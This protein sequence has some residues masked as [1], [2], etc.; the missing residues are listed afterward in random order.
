[1]PQDSGSPFNILDVD[2]VV[3]DKFVV[4]N[5]SADYAAGIMI[6]SANNIITNITTV[7]NRGPGI[8]LLLPEAPTAPDNNTI[9][10]VHTTGNGKC[11]IYITEGNSNTIIN[12]TSDNNGSNG[13]TVVNGNSNQILNS[14]IT[15]NAYEGF[16][17]W[18]ATD[19][20]IRGN[21][22]EGNGEYGIYLDIASSSNTIYNNKFSNTINV[23]DD[24]DSPNTWN[25]TEKTAGTNI[26]GGSWL[27]GNFWSDYPGV[28]TNDDGI[29]DTL[30][31]YTAGG[32]ITNGGDWLPLIGNTG[33]VPVTCPA[34]ISS[35]GVYE[36]QNDCSNTPYNQPWD[37]IRITSSDV[38]FDGMG[39]TIDGKNS[40]GWTTVHGVYAYT[41]SALSNITVKNVTVN[42][43]W[44]GIYYYQVSNGRIENITGRNSYDS[45]FLIYSTSNTVTNCSVTTS[46]GIALWPGS[47]SNT[48]TNNSVRDNSGIA[49]YN[50][51]NNIVTDNAIENNYGGVSVSGSSA[52]NNQLFH[53]TIRN[54]EVGI[55]FDAGSGAPGSN[56]IYDNYFSNTVNINFGKYLEFPKD[57]WHQ[58]Y[59][60][61]L[62]WRQ[63][64]GRPFRNRLFPDVS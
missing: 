41:G 29:G 14:T 52:I 63:L 17:L 2:G 54:N 61:F 8:Y 5:S 28:D 60:R 3:L 38:E 44:Q 53:N 25:L 47:N 11:G 59:R 37:G 27:G 1:M 56:F 48:I 49:I 35:P 6:H 16:N 4:T 20:L 40:P 58:Y 34:V 13:I 21:T 46:T 31:P 64:L 50:A 45:I 51:Q 19:T 55:V 7:D 18:G 33:P 22:I 57:I 39:H 15:G 9:S 24:A 62:P 12:V 26:L 10:N 30:V 23:V 36:L 32:S 42:G 43:T